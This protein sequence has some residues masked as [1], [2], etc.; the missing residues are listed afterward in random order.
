MMSRMMSR[1]DFLFN[2][3]SYCRPVQSG[4]PLDGKS[5]KYSSQKKIGSSEKKDIFEK[6][7]SVTTN[8][9][10]DQAVYNKIMDVMDEIDEILEE[11]RDPVADIH[12][13]LN[14]VK[15]PEEA[16]QRLQSKKIKTSSVKE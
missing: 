10:S 5:K 4:G 15:K 2:L 9:S 11:S 8:T 7:I 13:L 16:I 12:A 14:I 3:G 1:I 6:S